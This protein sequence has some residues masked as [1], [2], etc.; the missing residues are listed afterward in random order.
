MLRIWNVGRTLQA[1]CENVADTLSRRSLEATINVESTSDDNVA[2]T[3]LRW[4]AGCEVITIS[5][6]TKALELSP[7]S[8]G[9]ANRPI[10]GD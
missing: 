3:K 10:C 8:K 5:V 7:C 6:R 9:T 1:R 4:L 2:Y